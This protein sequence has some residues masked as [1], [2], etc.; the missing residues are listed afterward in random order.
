LN[1][2]TLPV[3]GSVDN[4]SSNDFGT[5]A[6]L[7]DSGVVMNDHQSVSD[8]GSFTTPNTA[9]MAQDQFEDEFED[10]L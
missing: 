5:I 4:Q 2:P 10:E 7:D 1:N 3:L 9:D 8:I 6:S